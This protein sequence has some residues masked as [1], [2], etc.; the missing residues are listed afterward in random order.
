MKRTLRTAVFLAALTHAIASPGAADGVS[1]AHATSLAGAFSYYPVLF[2][3][4]GE[5]RSTFPPWM[6][7]SLAQVSI[8]NDAVPGVL[9]SLDFRVDPPD[10]WSLLIHAGPDYY[11]QTLQFRMWSLEEV[12][13]APESDYMLA[14]V[15][16]PMGHYAAG[17]VLWSGQFG[18]STEEDP[19]FSIELWANKT[20]D[21][22]NE[23]LL[24]TFE[25]I[26][27]PS[28]VCVLLCGLTAF[29][30]LRRRHDSSSRA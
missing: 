16:D 11:Y 22:L 17:Q 5:R 6:P 25:P 1:F 29:V 27:E 21:P 24:L 13:F 10:A 4:Y 7:P 28:T 8:L 19:V 26:P 12:E 3:Q 15:N 20:D 30:P 2:G 9:L 18:A 23:G 14:V